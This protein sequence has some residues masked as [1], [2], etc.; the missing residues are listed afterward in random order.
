MA[1]FLP[2]YREID[3]RPEWEIKAMKITIVCLFLLIPL[4]IL[5]YFAELSIPEQPL[6][7]IKRLIESGML[8][9]ESFSPYS[10]SLYYQSLATHR[11][12]ETSSLIANAQA[13]GNF[14]DVL[15]PS[16]AT[17]L[18]IVTSS[19]Q[20]AAAS[21]TIAN[22]QQKKAAQAQLAMSLETYQMQLTQMHYTIQQSLTQ[23]IPQPTLA[24]TPTP[25]PLPKMITPTNSTAATNLQ[26]Q[27]AQTLNELQTIMKTLQN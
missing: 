2:E 6:Y 18:E 14:S 12:S 3:T 24:Q 13:T 22:P 21:N 27:I 15:A 8:V 20:A 7:P 17:L 10:K 19:Q 23:P 1:R 4:G 9:V 11:M 25:T 5:G 26:N 16:D